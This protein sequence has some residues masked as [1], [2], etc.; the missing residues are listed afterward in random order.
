MK[1]GGGEPEEQSNPAGRSVS[2]WIADVAVARDYRLAWLPH[3]AMAG[4]SLSAV[5]V[6]AGMACAEAPARGAILLDKA[7]ARPRLVRRL[8]LG[9]ELSTATQ[10][11]RVDH[12]VTSP[13]LCVT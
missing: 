7:A 10:R 2:R 6:P 1:T 5:L 3:D 8:T 9:P 11:H 12:T 4:V 13:N